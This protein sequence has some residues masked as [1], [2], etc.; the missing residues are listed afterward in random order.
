MKNIR[1]FLLAAV[2]LAAIAFVTSTPSISAAPV[3]DPQHSALSF[4]LPVATPLLAQITPPPAGPSTT[5]AVAAPWY[6]SLLTA[7]NVAL[8]IGLV[9]SLIAI[10]KN[11][12]LT[13]SQKSLRAV[14]VGVETATQHPAVQAEAAKIKAAIQSYAVSHG[15][16]N[17]LYTLVQDITAQLPAAP[18]P[19]PAEPTPAAAAA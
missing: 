11:K 19:K 4:D 1:S 8:V 10:A 18:E 17:E 7:E 2:A 6:Q 3:A 14:I 15:V 16:E 12:A 9:S 13:T 5:P